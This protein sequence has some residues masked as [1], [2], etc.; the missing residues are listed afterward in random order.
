MKVRFPPFTVTSLVNVEKPVTFRVSAFMFAVL[1]PVTVA[2]P[3]AKET[4]N[5]EPKSIV[6]A[7]PTGDVLFLI[8]TPLP[9]P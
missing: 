7:V 4:F 8:P 6:P 1:I 5:P 9:T 3:E 2:I